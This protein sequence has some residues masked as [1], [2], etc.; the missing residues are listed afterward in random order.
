MKPSGFTVG[1]PTATAVVLRIAAILS[2]A[3]GAI[4]SARL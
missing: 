4:A 3:L 1:R 2:V